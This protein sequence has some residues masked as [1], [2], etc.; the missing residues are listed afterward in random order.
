MPESGRG[1]RTNWVQKNGDGTN[2]TK[3]GVDLNHE[4]HIFHLLQPTRKKHGLE[5]SPACSECKVVQSEE[6]VS[7]HPPEI[8]F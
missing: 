7:V 2:S 3:H 5:C 1:S 8:N 4:Q 6:G